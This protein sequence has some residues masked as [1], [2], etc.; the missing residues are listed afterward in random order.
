[1]HVHSFGVDVGSEPITVRVSVL[2]RGAL[3][4]WAG[5]EGGGAAGVHA[6]RG[7]EHAA[8]AASG[9]LMR[10]FAVAMARPPATDGATNGAASGAAPRGTAAGTA[11]SHAGE[12][13][14]P[15][16]QRI[17]AQP[18]TATRL[19]IPQLF[20]S[21]DLS[22]ALAPSVSGDAG[23]ERRLALE[24]GIRRACE[25]ALSARGQLHNNS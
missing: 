15:M 8:H 11:L 9:A 14:L 4:V 3:F 19:A 7:A 25:A 16:A 17:G 13:A 10:D 23:A 2:E 24:L 22:P 18:L 5:R 12:L 21:L 6:A 1:M 20:L